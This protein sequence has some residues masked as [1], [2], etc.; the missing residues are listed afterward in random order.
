MFGV[1]T[2]SVL[3]DNIGTVV[4]ENGK[5]FWEGYVIQLSF[6]ILLACH[7]PFIFFSGKEGMLIIIDEIDRK[8]ISSALWH[9]LYAAGGTFEQENKDKMPANPELPIPGDDTPFMDK[10]TLQASA[11]IRETTRAS[12]LMS[13]KD[14]LTMMSVEE[15]NRLA[16]KDM[17]QS[18]YYGSVLICWAFVLL[19]SIVIESVTIV[20]DFASAFAITA[21]AFIFPAMFY[22]K[23][24]E[25][26]G[27]GT[28]I[29]RFT[30]YLFY[31]LGGL[32]CILG[33]SST[34]L[35]IMG[36]E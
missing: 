34:I 7:I 15:S 33:L 23:A 18:Y 27:G 36:G 6:M 1:N 28:P 30:C 35:N 10:P 8:S 12:Q 14:R 21:I 26:F 13:A 31:G 11:E 24:V 3:L 5:H 22:L 16:Y 25:R 32:N 17:K 20:F 2:Q 9:K 19:L 4:R 29:R